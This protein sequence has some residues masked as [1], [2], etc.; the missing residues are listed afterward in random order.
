MTIPRYDARMSNLAP[1]VEERAR[2][3]LAAIAQEVLDLRGPP[4]IPSLRPDPLPL[5]RREAL[6]NLFAEAAVHHVTLR[7]LDESRRVIA[8]AIALM[9]DIVDPAVVARASLLTG[10]A[11]VELDSPK[12]AKLRLEVAVRFYHMARDA[13]LLARARLGLARALIL[14]ED[15]QGLDLLHEVHADASTRGDL[16]M[17]ARIEAILPEAMGINASESVR[18]GYGRA[19]SIPPPT[20]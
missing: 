6:L 3:R 2:R 20:R 19:V 14:L 12:H 10:E 18:A 17:I 11:L 13:K 9:D 4:P 5:D 16:A 8:D 15:P 7:E 1:E